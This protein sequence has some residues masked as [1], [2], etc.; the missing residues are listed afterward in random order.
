VRRRAAHH[1]YACEPGMLG[2]CPASSRR[3]QPK[4]Q[5]AM[6]VPAAE[7]TTLEWHMVEPEHEVSVAEIEHWT[8]WPK[9]PKCRGLKCGTYPNL[10]AKPRWPKSPKC[11]GLSICS[12]QTR[13]GALVALPASARHSKRK[14]TASGALFG[15]RRWL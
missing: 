11:G 7:M 14:R 2:R 10:D 12:G 1:P 15:V 8:A 6:M 13:G 5:T 3:F 4:E 9:C